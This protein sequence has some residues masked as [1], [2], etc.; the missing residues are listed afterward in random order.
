MNLLDAGQVAAGCEFRIGAGVRRIAGVR[1][2]KV[3]ARPGAI[4]DSTRRRRGARNFT[5]G[6]WQALDPGTNQ[7]AGWG[8]WRQGARR[9]VV[10][11]NRC[12]ETRWTRPRRSHG[13]D[14]IDSGMPRAGDA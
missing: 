13:A 1:Q 3:V 9:A 11:S 7:I 8:V 5:P 10:R 14:S 12:G 4:A 2:P 6:P